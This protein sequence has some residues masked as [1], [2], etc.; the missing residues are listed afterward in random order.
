[1]EDKNSFERRTIKKTECKFGDYKTE[2]EI[3]H[4]PQGHTR[5]Q[6][7]SVDCSFSRFDHFLI[8]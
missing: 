1:M 2:N 5:S 7:I 4:I 6:K 8:T 3:K